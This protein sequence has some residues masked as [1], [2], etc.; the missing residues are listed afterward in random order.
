MGKKSAGLVIGERDWRE[1]SFQRTVT[2]A[3]LP[4]HSSRIALLPLLQ[5]QRKKKTRKKLLTS[6]FL[7][8]PFSFPFSFFQD[9]SLERAAENNEPQQFNIDPIGGLIDPDYDPHG[10]NGFIFGFP[11]EPAP[12]PPNRPEPARRSPAPPA[13][14]PGRREPAEQGRSGRRRP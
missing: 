9:S 2:N 3:W 6:S 1:F 8:L 4:T 13:G 10:V 14:P 7:S 5:Q 12:A 11:P